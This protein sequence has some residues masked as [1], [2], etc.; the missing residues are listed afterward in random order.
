VTAA[1]LPEPPTTRVTW[2]RHHRLVLSHYPPIDLYD[3]VADPRDWEALAAA[4]ARTNPRIYDQIGDLSRVPVARRISGDGASWA[5]AAFTHVSPDRQSRFSDG[6]HGVYYAGESLET[7]LHEHSF[8]MG[9]FYARSAMAPGWISEVRELVGAID[10]DLTDLRVGGF[11]ALL[12]PDDYTA[13]QAFA[14]RQRAGGADGI[15][16]P[17][18]RRAGGAC[19]AAFWPD[20]VGR[21]VPGAHF[22]YFW[23]GRHVAYAREITGERRIFQLRPV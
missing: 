11:G 5:M 19:I 16:Y 9:A 3:D 12:D 8:H 10:A 23:T 14:T 20:V 7:T 18:V 1:E 13:A 4:Q 6:G 22:R 15:V 2:P 21:P 17:S